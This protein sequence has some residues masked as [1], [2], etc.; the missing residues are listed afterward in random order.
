MGCSSPNIPC[1]PVHVT[2]V[3]PKKCNNG[4]FAGYPIPTSLVCYD[5]TILPN[6][7]VNP[8]DNLNVVLQKLDLALDPTT[9]V[10][11]MIQVINDNPSLLVAFCTLV[12]SCVLTP[13][14][15]TSTTTVAPTTTTTTTEQPTTTTTTTEAPTTTTTT[16]E[17]PTTTSTTT[18]SPTT[19]T[20]TTIP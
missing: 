18:D 8:H 6:S 11:N 10:Q 1:N 20:T 14:T 16:T 2:A 13:T 19:T 3:Y 15:T 4:W 5:G 9:L 17:V 7:G 12:N